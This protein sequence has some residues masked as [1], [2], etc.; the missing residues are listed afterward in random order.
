M[1]STDLFIGGGVPDYGTQQYL[2][3]KYANRHGLV[4]GAT[5]TG[6][7]ELAKLLSKNLDM[8]LLKYDM[9]E[10]GEK[11]SNLFDQHGHTV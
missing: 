2:S 10:Y 3:L 11:H 1:V 9:S 4:A 5:G 8:P 7:T 6:K